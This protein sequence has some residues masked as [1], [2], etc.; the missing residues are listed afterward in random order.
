MTSLHQ[1]R[2]YQPPQAVRIAA[3]T[4]ALTLPVLLANSFLLEAES[5]PAVVGPLHGMTYVL[6]VMFGFLVRHLRPG[7]WY[8]LV[9][10]IGGTLMLRRV[11]RAARPDRRDGA[12]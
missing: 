9:P 10:G 3:L 5:L 1:P 8:A 11:A 4:E 12:S 6:V 2:T 7:R